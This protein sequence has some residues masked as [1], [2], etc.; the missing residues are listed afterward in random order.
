MPQRC[1]FGRSVD[2]EKKGNCLE[3]CSEQLGA[4]AMVVEK[5][6]SASGG[7]SCEMFRGL[8]ENDV[9]ETEDVVAEVRGSS[10]MAR[11]GRE[12]RY[13]RTGGGVESFLRYCEL[14]VVYESKG[15]VGCGRGEFEGRDVDF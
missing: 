1:G 7:E 5:D 15:S 8:E 9:G 12:T 13:C 11:E 6:E 10:A 14:V 3:F 2:A 4:V